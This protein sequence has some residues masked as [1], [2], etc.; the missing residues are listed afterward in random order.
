MDKITLSRICASANAA[1]LASL[2]A[3]A[4][5]GH[6]AALLKGPEKTLVLLQVREP[7]RQSRFYLGE[8][9]AAHCVVELDGVRGA[10][11]LMGDDL[12]KA[13]DAAVLDAAHSGG[14]PGF[15]LVEPELLR[16]EEA[17]N[18]E[19]AKKAAEIRKT[20]VSFQSLEDREL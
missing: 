11:V 18:A 2:A 3:Q 15:A 6:K 8:L 10:A 16:L 1:L 20:K 14:F 9:L 4:A 12:D 5:E 7:V 19:L 13:K 17:R